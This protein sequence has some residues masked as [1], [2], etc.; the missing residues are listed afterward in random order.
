MIKKPNIFFFSF[1]FYLVFI[2]NLNANIQEKLIFK[3]SNIQT[4]TFDFIQNIGEK[5]EIGNC[6][7]KY[8]LLMKCNYQNFKGK[9]I[10]SNGK[11]MAVIKKNTKKFIIIL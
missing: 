1:F 5:E 4:L 3:L 8:P 2:N 7:I 11:T 6:F 10:I 9:V